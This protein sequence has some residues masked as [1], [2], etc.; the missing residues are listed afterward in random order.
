[1]TK[2]CAARAVPAMVHSAAD[3]AKAERINRMFVRFV[4]WIV[5][6]SAD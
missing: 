3:A 5:G 4:R 1:V 2:I 6:E